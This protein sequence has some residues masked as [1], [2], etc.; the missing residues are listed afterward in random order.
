MNFK[1]CFIFILFFVFLVFPLDSIAQ[2]S[3]CRAVAESSYAGGSNT[4]KGL[5]DAI[6]YLMSL[7]YLVFLIAGF[8]VY[9]KFVAQRS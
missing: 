6:L 7:P 4:G 3:M 5:N 1:L 9:K 8:V 2:C